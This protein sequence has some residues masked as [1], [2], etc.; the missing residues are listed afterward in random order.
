MSHRRNR[1]RLTLFVAWFL[2]VGV[3]SSVLGN[4]RIL[5]FGDSNTWGW[6][7]N[8]SGTRYPD[9]ERWTGVLQNELGSEYTVISDGLVARRTNLDGMTAG[10]VDGVFLNGAKTLPAAIARN[11]PVDLVILFL[12][13]NDL[14][15][16]AE[17]SAQ[18]ISD[19]VGELAQLVTQSENLL[20]AN[21]P[22]PDVMVVVPPALGDLSNSP[23]KG[24]FQVGQAES[25]QLSAA[26]L[27]LGEQ[28]QLE[29]IDGKL[30]FPDGIGP[31]G[32]HLNNKGHRALGLAI[33]QKIKKKRNK[34]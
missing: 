33:S 24:L 20:Y 19:A 32:I 4:Y 34:L 21:Y 15:A 11:A 30:L 2:L 1:L 26:F 10:L 18:E 9:A 29:L 27:S 7:P 6:V 13:T 25:Q 5:A 3:V 31:D 8:G 22:A 14:Q 23:L 12:G 17:R 28:D 16:G